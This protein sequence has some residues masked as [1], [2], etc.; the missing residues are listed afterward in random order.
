MAVAVSAKG[1][2]AALVESSERAI[3]REFARLVPRIGEAVRRHCP[4]GRVT[5]ARRRLI[6]ADVDAIL[7]AVY[8]HRRG[9]PSPLLAIVEGHALTAYGTP[10]V[11]EA[12]R[13]RPVLARHP[14]LG[15]GVG[16]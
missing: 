16:S 10:T 5:W 8:G 14:D 6:L 4:D 9:D 7:D 12:E 13:V 15:S 3:D 2:L 1:D 11:R